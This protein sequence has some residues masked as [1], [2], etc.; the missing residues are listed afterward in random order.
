MQMVGDAVRIGMRRRRQHA[1]N[2]C[3]PLPAARRQNAGIERVLG[4]RV[5]ESNAGSPIVGFHEVRVARPLDRFED[6]FALLTRSTPG[7]DAVR[8]ALKLS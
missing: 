6:A 2:A 3:V 5:D 4:Q 1:G 7:H 8:V